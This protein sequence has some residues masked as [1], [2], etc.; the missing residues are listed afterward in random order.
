MYLSDLHCCGHIRGELI[1]REINARCPNVHIDAKLNMMSSD[2]LLA[3]VLVFQRQTDPVALAKMHL[4]RER[5]IKCIYDLDD[6]LFNLPEKFSIPYQFFGRKDVRETIGLFLAS[7]DAVTVSTVFLA[8]QVAKLT[9][10]PIFVLPNSLDV[11]QNNYAFTERLLLRTEK[12]DDEINIM[13]FASG[14]HNLDMPIIVNPINKI[15][16]KHKNVH[17]TLMGVFEKEA[18][19]LVAKE[20]PDRVHIEGWNEI[21]VLPMS[22]VDCDI[23]IA[24]LEDNLF[25]RSKSN[26]KFLHYSCLG[27]PTVASKLE[28]YESIVDGS[29]GFLAS[30]EDEWFDRLDKLVQDQALRDSLGFRARM[31]V[32]KQYDISQTYSKWLQ[33][34]EHVLRG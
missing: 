19:E 23:G 32:I 16:D 29:T 26:V 6:D 27:I 5:G 20:H 12:K 8:Q 7:V 14:S 30:N 15:M 25:N 33:V 24:P 11:E 2:F 31:Q 22:M 10:K 28:P 9:S 3:N 18:I 17:L 4:A 1:A 13:W 21:N 34:F